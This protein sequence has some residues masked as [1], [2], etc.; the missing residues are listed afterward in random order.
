MCFKCGITNC[1]CLDHTILGGTQGQSS[2]FIVSNKFT[3]MPQSLQKVEVKDYVSGRTVKQK[4]YFLHGT[5]TTP[6][7]I[8]SSGGLSPA[9]GTEFVI[10]P[11][12]NLDEWAG[13]LF[14][15]A[16]PVQ[17]DTPPDS[18]K[19]KGAAA[20]LWEDFPFVYCFWVPSNTKFYQPRKIQ[21]D[22][23]GHKQDGIDLSPGSE[24]A[25]KIEIP[26]S[27]IQ[28]IFQLNKSGEYVKSPALDKSSGTCCIL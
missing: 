26:W 2:G 4:T 21:R 27:Q 22:T 18:Y 10:T 7:D 25:F 19:H 15:L 3:Y 8:K 24:T 13:H 1:N 6:K 12:K 17:G 14:L 20:K 16:F 11:R 23:S 28:V 9:F 5:R